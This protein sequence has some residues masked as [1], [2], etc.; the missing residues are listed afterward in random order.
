MIRTLIKSTRITWAA[1]NVNMYLLVLTYA[2]FADIVIKNPIQIFEGL[3][4]VSA[5]WGALYSLN[6]LTDI[7]H[8]RQDKDKKHRPFIQVNIDKKYIIIFFIAVI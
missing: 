8:D 2:Y 7:E 4:L 3:I 1:K 5:L 6:D